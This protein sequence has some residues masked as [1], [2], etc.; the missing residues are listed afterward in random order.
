MDARQALRPQ[1]PLAPLYARGSRW[2]R[3]SLQQLRHRLPL[4]AIG[5]W[6]A[7]DTRLGARSFV[8]QALRPLTCLSALFSLTHRSSR[9]RSAWQW[10]LR[11]RRA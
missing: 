5:V 10:V 7:L 1:Q 3:S 2:W 9:P 6:L 4:M 11:R 8:L